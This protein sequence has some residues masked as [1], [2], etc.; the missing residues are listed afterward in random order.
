MF[1]NRVPAM[2]ASDSPSERYS[3]MIAL[4]RMAAAALV[5]ALAACG[6]SDPVADNAQN[7]DSL[8]TIATNTASADG[9]APE[10][11]TTSAVGNSAV[12]AASTSIPQA[13][14]GR[15]G[16]TPEDCTSTRGDAKGLLT[17]TDNELRFY[18]SRAVPA[19]NVQVS[20]DSISAD[21]AFTGE[22]MNWTK[23][24]TLQ[25]QDGKLV[26]TESGPMA[27]FTYV[28]CQ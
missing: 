27:S 18:E 12:A 23:F 15:W 7:S 17:V 25:L 4:H 5:G 19:D 6:S 9:S 16:M 11:G 21:F 10:Q 26:R 28:P 1:L 14:R 3:G 8:P 2:A 24:Q 13:L 22:G 20:P